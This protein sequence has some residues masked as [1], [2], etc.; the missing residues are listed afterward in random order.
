[1]PGDD[2]RRV[3]ERRGDQALIVKTPGDEITGGT[4]QGH[5]ASKDTPYPGD[6]RAATAQRLSQI[7]E[8]G[9]S[10]TGVELRP[11]SPTR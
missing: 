5:Q 11:R 7:A 4:G 1:V 10:E 3:G 2:L 6:D 9:R 8:T